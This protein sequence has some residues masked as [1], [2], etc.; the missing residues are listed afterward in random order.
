MSE[1]DLTRYVPALIGIFESTYTQ[2]SVVILRQDFGLTLAEARIV[3][4][5]GANPGFSG[6]Q[7]SKAFGIDPSLIS[8]S[9][10]KLT[11]RDIIAI[12]RDIGH[13]RRQM[14]SLTEAGEI[15][16]KR[17]VEFSLEREAVLLGDFSPLEREWLISLLQKLLAGAPTA[18]AFA[19]SRGDLR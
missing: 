6:L 2:A 5:I 16:N 18:N 3:L 4:V 1:F 13:A 17:L 7:V 8:R 12:E 9:L 10:R 19:H 14:L 11:E 15:L